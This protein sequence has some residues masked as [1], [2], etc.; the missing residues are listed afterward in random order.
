MYLNLADLHTVIAQ[1][2]HELPQLKTAP[3][4]WSIED[5]T[6]PSNTKTLKHLEPQYCFQLNHFQGE[7]EWAFIL[8]P[9]TDADENDLAEP[10]IKA[11]ASYIPITPSG[12][13]YCLTI[14]GQPLE[15]WKI[16]PQ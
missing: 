7:F 14:F 10:W 12:G 8:S 9:F 5:I 6:G 1:I 13:H 2:C 4:T 16:K 3:N 15:T 11:D